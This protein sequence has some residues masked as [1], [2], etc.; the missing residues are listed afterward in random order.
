MRPMTAFVYDAHLTHML[1]LICLRGA[2]RAGSRPRRWHYAVV[3][4]DELPDWG[5]Y[6]ICAHFKCTRC[7]SVGWVDPRPN[8]SEV[9]NYSKGVS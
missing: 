1:D 8:W 2:A 5:W 6:D 4:L 7:G 3:P 9:I